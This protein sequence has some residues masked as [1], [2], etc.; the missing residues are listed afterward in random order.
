MEEKKKITIRDIAA[1]AGVDKA[2]VSKI[3]NNARVIPASKEKIARVKELIERYSYTPSSSAR[4][5]VTSRTRQLLFLL[6]DSTT[7]GIGNEGF[8]QSLTGVM[9]TC[10]AK[11]YLCQI[12]MSDFSAVGSFMLPENLRRR[13]VDGCILTGGF[14]TEALA[15]IAE[16]DCPMVIIGG[17]PLSKILPVIS[18]RSAAD[19]PRLL[20]YCRLKG[21][22]RCW[23]LGGPRENWRTYF[24]YEAKFPEM[25]LRI[26]D[27]AEFDRQDE[28][29]FGECCAREF[30]AL[31]R[32]DRPSLIFGTHQFCAAFAAVTERAGLH[33]PE[34]FSMISEE[35]AA[36][37]RYRT[38]P[39]TVFGPDFVQS[40]VI[41]AEV[42][43]EIIEKKLPPAEAAALAASR[44]IPSRFIERNS[45]RTLT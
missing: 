26:I 21:H 41:A 3:I 44:P 38:E 31:D 12:E 23:L 13:S 5:L 6:S 30:R 9:K 24:E 15:S 19:Y 45:V 34:D 2:V 7:Q 39:L 20:D 16:T 29:Y 42:L 14:A 37:I 43:C 28:F 11:G 27:R 40:G 10:R 36:L 18:R 1:L 8:A 32:I 17:E 25:K 33:I 4:S 35:D 22:R